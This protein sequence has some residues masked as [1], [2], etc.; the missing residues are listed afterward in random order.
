MDRRSVLSVSAITALGLALLPGNTFAQ[1][2][3]HVSF[4]TP[5]ENTK[6][7][8]KTQNLEIGDVP[9]HVLRVFEIRRTYP[10]NAPVINGAKIV[11]SAD[12]ILEE[13]QLDL[14][15]SRS[16]RAGAREPSPPS[17]GVAAGM[18]T[19]TPSAARRVL[20]RLVPGEAYDLDALAELTGLQPA[21][22]LPRLFELEIR[23]LVRRA[24]GGQFVRI[25]RSC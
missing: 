8:E 9:N 14:E 7:T 12:D 4:S 23:G 6:N 11:E 20:A 24:G 19:G 13:L 2:K 3:Q 10:N 1:E 21:E 22:L 16:R 15:A 5:A 25:D 17:Q 18:S